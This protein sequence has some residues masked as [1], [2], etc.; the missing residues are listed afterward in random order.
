MTLAAPL[1]W[2]DVLSAEAADEFS[3]A[4]DDPAVPVDESNLVLKAARAFRSATGWPGGAKF[5]LAK[6]IPIG[7]GLGGGSS[8]AVAAL[9]ALNQLAG[10]GWDEAALGSM[11]AKLGSDCPLFLSEGPV[12]A[13]GRGELTEPVP[14]SAAARLHGR[15]VAVF[16]PGFAVATAWAYGRMRA[17]SESYIAASAAEAKLAAWLEDRSAAA[18]ELLFNNMEGPVFEKFAALPAML[19]WLRRDFG[20]APRMSGSGSACF[21]LLPAQ[22]GPEFAA[23]AAAIRLAWGESAFVMETRLS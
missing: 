10:G 14:P 16:K 8:N 20:L 13:R 18:E 21:A 22:G 11:A 7:A 9:R 1:E 4:C 23:L 5:V 2:G 17:A 12:V 15:R 6:R 3:L 19:E